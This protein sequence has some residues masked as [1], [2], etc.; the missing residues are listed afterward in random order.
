MINAERIA[1]LF[2]TMIV[3]ILFAFSKFTLLKVFPIVSNASVFI[4]F[5]ASL[6]KD[7]KLKY[8]KDITATNSK[9]NKKLV[10]LWTIFFFINLGVSIWTAFLPDWIWIIYNGIILYLILVI[11]FYFSKYKTNC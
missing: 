5:L 11:L 2:L 9:I 10:L 1:P 7:E 4:I 6:L 3:V 8:E